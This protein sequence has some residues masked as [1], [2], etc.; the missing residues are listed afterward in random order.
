MFISLIMLLFS[1]FNTISVSK[2]ITNID[3]PSCRFCNY[4]KPSYLDYELDTMLWTDALQARTSNKLDSETYINEKT[5]ITMIKLAK[6][7]DIQYLTYFNV[8][9]HTKKTVLRKQWYTKWQSTDGK[10]GV[11][12]LGYVLNNITDN[13]KYRYIDMVHKPELIFTS[14]LIFILSI[15]IFQINSFD[16]SHIKSVLLLILLNAYLTMFI[17]TKENITSS[18]NEIE[19]NKIISSNI[20]GISFLTGV[21]IF[22][23]N[24]IY[25][26][27][28][29]LFIE[30]ASIFGVSILLL[31]TALFK[32]TNQNYVDEVI[33]AR[34][35]NQ[36]VFNVA[37]FLNGLIIFN[38]VFYTFVISKLKHYLPFYK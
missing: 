2:Q 32:S 1:T 9:P 33:G 8:D 34:I 11:I 19:K 26:K 18:K 22:I 37:V 7:N 29:K 6:L 17:N 13:S 30:T 4:F 10:E 31:L 23:M 3:L 15:V 35:T 5:P 27:H 36:L 28:V 16:K 25:K 12:C 20:L 38:F 24:F 21:S 14:I